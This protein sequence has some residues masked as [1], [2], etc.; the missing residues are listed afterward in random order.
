MSAA[1]RLVRILID[2]GCEAEIDI[3]TRGAISWL[4]EAG[5][6]ESD[7][8]IALRQ[9]AVQGWI[10]AQRLGTTRLTPDAIAASAKNGLPH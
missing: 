9:T 2:R 1:L 10:G 4:I 3:D 8:L 5:I 7:C 6:E